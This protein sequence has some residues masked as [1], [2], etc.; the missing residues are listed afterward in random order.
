[1]ATEQVTPVTTPNG[2][3]TPAAVTTVIVADDGNK[4]PRLP[5]W[6]RQ[7]IFV[8]I[9][10]KRVAESQLRRGRHVAGSVGPAGST[11]P[12]WVAISTYCGRHGVNR[13]PVQCRKR[14]SNLSGDFK[15]IKEWELKVSHGTELESFWDMR[16]DLRKERC[17]PGFF[18]REIFYKLDDETVTETVMT[19]ITT[20][21]VKEEENDVAVSEAETN[22]EVEGDV[23]FDS[24]RSVAVNDG[25][26]SDTETVAVATPSPTSVMKVHAPVPISERRF[27]PIYQENQ[28][29]GLA[30]E[31][32]H[33][34]NLE[35]GSTSQNERKRKRS[36]S[37]EDENSTLQ[38]QMFKLLEK[39]S[40]ML[41]AHL[42]AQKTN[43]E[44]DREQRKDQGA[45]LVEVLSKLAE[46]LV[47]IAEKL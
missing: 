37:D 11:E 35:K 17:L 7:E 32:Q 10:G 29:Q 4:P 46:A 44:L 2:D 25:L 20:I 41:T 39:N 9:Q 36:L 13:S 24:G 6:T 33:A 40:D 12:K 27:E 42:E 22:E 34:V 47:K 16:N 26:F 15:K 3:I 21:R 30:N 18:D 1:M 28:A 45:S 5:R 19:P 38:E 43:S 14:W 23:V 8:L 31:K